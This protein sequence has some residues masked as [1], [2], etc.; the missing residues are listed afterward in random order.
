M[1]YQ[2]GWAFTQGRCPRI[3]TARN[4]LVPAV[5]AVEGLDILAQPL[6][7]RRQGHASLSPHQTAIEGMVTQP[8]DFLHG[9]AVEG[10]H[11][12][13]QVGMR[14]EPEIVEDQDAVAVARLV[15]LVVGRRTDPIA[16]SC[17]SSSR[18]AGGF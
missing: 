18:D 5:A 6:V 2:I 3:R 16:G 9:V 7:E 13:R 12:V 4:G 15:E 11:V 1:K 17:C 14:I 10:E 8:L